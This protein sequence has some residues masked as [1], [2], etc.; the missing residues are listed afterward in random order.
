[1][2]ELLKR[3]EELL[4][5]W[6]TIC[7][8]KEP[9]SH[10]V[11]DGLLYRG[12]IHYN[13]G[14]WDR[15]PSNNEDNLWSNVPIKIIFLMKD[16]TNLEMDDIRY[17]T[18]RRNDIPPHFDPIKRDAFSMNILYWL[19]GLT[20]VRK[21]DMVPFSEIENGQICFDF[22]EK[23]PLVR[24]NCKK[25]SG[26]SSISN[27]LL[28]QY[29]SDSDYSKLL[30]E[31]IELFE[32]DIIVCCGGNSQ[33]KRYVSENIYTSCEKINNWMF[34]DSEKKKLIIDSY[35]PSYYSW[36]RQSL[37][38]VLMKNYLEFLSMNKDFQEK[39]E[40]FAIFEL[41]K[42]KNYKYNIII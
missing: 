8:E 26:G 38:E 32:A 12:D 5:Q 39:M 9:K 31:Q 22:Y 41:K 21:L 15:E 14:N 37:Y 17:E 30:K 10:F 19:Y 34:Y 20:H 18:M 35:H 36:S 27:S 29:L 23:Y 11:K 4:G 6:V 40:K 25:V 16:F 13:G 2:G 28:Y 1:M 7:K 42:L 3:N 24:I 33:I